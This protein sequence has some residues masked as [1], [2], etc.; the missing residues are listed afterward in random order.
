MNDVLISHR[1]TILLVDDT[2]NNLTVLNAILKDTYKVRIA[3]NG[4]Q[5][6]RL[7]ERLPIPDLILLDVMM[8][9][10]DGFEVCRSLKSNV[11][12]VDIPVIFLTAKTQEVDEIKGF[13]VGG[14]RLFTQTIKS[15]D[16][17]NSS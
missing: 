15:S 3:N 5:A 13:N 17:L 1:R 9:G 14:G 6:L 4:E 16:C 8:P 7:A 11:S 12:T 2:P 10:M